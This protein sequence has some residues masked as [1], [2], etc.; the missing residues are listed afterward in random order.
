MRASR[1]LLLFAG[2]LM[3]AGCDD[4]GGVTTTVHPPM[5]L[6]RFVAAV[7]DRGGTDWRFIDQLEYSPPGFN[8]TFRSFT[9][10]QQ[11]APGARR[12]RVFPTSSDITVTSQP[13]F[14]ETITFEPGRYYTIIHAGYS[15]GSPAEQLIILEDDVPSIEAGDFAIRALNLGTGLA[16]GAGGPVDIYAAA[17]TGAALPGDLFAP[18]LAFGAA[19]AYATRDT[20]ALVLRAL[21]AGTVTP[22][23]AN[24]AAPA[25]VA[26][27]P[28]ANLTTIGGTRMDQSAMFALSLPGSVVGS[29][30]PQTSAF[31]AQTGAAD[32]LSVTTTGYARQ[33]G[34]F[35]TAG[36]TVGMQLTAAGFGPR[37][38]AQDSLSATA[39]G[40]S[41]QTGSFV[42]QG[43]TVGMQIDATGFTNASNNGLS[44]ITAVTPLALVVN[45]TPATVPEDPN[46][47]RSLRST[48]DNNGTSV[49]TGVTASTLTVDKTPALMPEGPNTGRSLRSPRPAWVYIITRHPR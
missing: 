20:G 35:I 24:T 44:V 22:A 3:I 34:S 25:G 30:A 4:D 16:A 11:T 36:F 5:A 47:G 21:A 18:N 27:N 28:S 19:S 41:R 12:L 8:L 49:I 10:Y 2:A 42:T 6:T 15:G 40:Y 17:T 32:A 39:T 31:V 46:T 38:D 43:F 9:P 37:T 13:I 48:V 1:I 7:P 23:L 14:D 33:S 29:G 45:K 26:G